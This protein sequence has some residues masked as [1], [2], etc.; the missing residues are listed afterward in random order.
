MKTAHT[1]PRRHNA[2]KTSLHPFFN[3][4]QHTQN[5]RHNK[6]PRLKMGTPP[7]PSDTPLRKRQPGT[8]FFPLT[9]DPPTAAHFPPIRH[10][11]HLRKKS[12]R[13]NMSKRTPYL[14]K[15]LAFCCHSHCQKLS[16]SG[17]KLSFIVILL[18]PY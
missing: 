12:P 11:H 18:R 8:S 3:Y 7:A 15:S 10:N 14:S 5:A 6:T 4:T 2:S 9:F 1:V 13:R 16:K 17:L